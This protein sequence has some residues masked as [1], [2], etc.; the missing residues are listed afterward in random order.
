MSANLYE[1]KDRGEYFHIHGS[2]EATQTL[3]MIG[4]DAFRPDLKNHD[5]IVSVIEPAVQKYSVQ[6]LEALNLLHRQAG[7]P[8]FRHE[9]FVRTRHVR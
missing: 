2:L 1:T 4:L 6:E 8:A 3:S 9:D 5:D 7:I